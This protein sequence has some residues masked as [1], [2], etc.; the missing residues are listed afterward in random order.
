[1]ESSDLTEVLVALGYRGARHNETVLDS[2]LEDL[3]CGSA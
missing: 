3:D 1:M 2:D